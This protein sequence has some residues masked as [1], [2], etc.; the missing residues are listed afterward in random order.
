[1]IA[2]SFGESTKEESG[3]DFAAKHLCIPFFFPS[4]RQPNS[5]KNIQLLVVVNI[6]LTFQTIRHEAL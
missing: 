5:E 1:M 2:L 6:I 3:Q 4:F